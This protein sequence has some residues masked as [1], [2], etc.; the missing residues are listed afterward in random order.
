ML[1]GFFKLEPAAPSDMALKALERWA[2]GEEA[3]IVIRAEDLERLVKHIKEWRIVYAE[4]E[5]IA[6]AGPAR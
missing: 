3:W 4:A 2:P 6:G 1:S 5:R